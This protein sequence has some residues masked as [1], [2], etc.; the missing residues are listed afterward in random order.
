MDPSAQDGLYPFRPPQQILRQGLSITLEGT[1]T[2]AGSAVDMST[3]VRNLSA[4]ASI[5][6]WQ[7][8]V[9][10]TKNAA[11][12]LGREWEGRKGRLEKGWDGDMVVLDG[13]GRVK[14]TWVG[15][16]EVWKRGGEE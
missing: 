4:F 8:I 6:L 10:C 14:A 5:P 7:A 12:A 15:G 2:L 1:S 3:C 13:E 11:R 9:C 16:R